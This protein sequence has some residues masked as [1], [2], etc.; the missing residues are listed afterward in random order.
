MDAEHAAEE[1][2]YIAHALEA[3]YIDGEQLRA[4]VKAIKA[5]Q[6]LVERLPAREVSY[7]LDDEVRRDDLNKRAR[8]AVIALR[9]SGY[10]T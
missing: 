1:L 9:A 7:A 6:V 3:E 8:D 4:A 10:W 2:S 5:A